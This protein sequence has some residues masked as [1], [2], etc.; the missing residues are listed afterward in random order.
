VRLNLKYKIPAIY[1]FDEFAREGGV[2]PYGTSDTIGVKGVASYL[3]RIFRG[4]HPADMPAQ[5]PTRA[6]EVIE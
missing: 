4:E 1:S 5:A 2:I 3:D 6:D